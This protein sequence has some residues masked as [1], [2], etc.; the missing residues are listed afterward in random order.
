MLHKQVKKDSCTKQE[1]SARQVS[2]SRSQSKMDDHGN[3]R[4][5][6]SMSRNH[7]YPNKSTRRTHASSWT[8]SNPSV[9]PVWRQRR[10]HEEDILK[11]EL[12]KVKPLTFN[13]EH[14][15][16]EEV[17]AWLLEMKK[18]FQLHDYPSRVEAIIST[19][20]MEG[21]ESI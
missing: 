13:G 10:R 2:T 7:H 19:Y 5:S 3:D 9:S 1:T 4:K 18:Y 20:H 21:K 8:R 6:I 15:K 12:M 17:E 16:G 14:W 11:G